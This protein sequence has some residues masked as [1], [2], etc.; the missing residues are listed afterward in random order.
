MTKKEILAE[1]IAKGIAQITILE[2]SAPEQ[3]N[4]SAVV[5][6]GQID[7][8]RKFMESRAG[9]FDPKKSHAKINKTTG[10]IGLIIDETNP[11]DFYQITGTIQQ[12]RKFQDLKIN[13][14][15]K[16]STAELSLKLRMLRSLFTSVDEH[17][18][19]V[20]DLRN[21]NAKVNKTIEK[22]DDLKGNMSDLFTQ[23]VESNI[24][25][26][27]TLAVPIIEG[28]EKVPIQVNIILTVGDS[29]QIL[30]EL[31]SVDAAEAW[32]NVIEK[33]MKEE[34]AFLEQNTTAIFV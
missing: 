7:A 11:H 20:N 19:I 1:M 23:T 30:C 5:I 9:E 3:L 24:P 26:A 29:R 12:S 8:P 6:T 32:D 4:P 18:K 34:I 21:L 13:T 17:A 15:H 31:E 14:G 28:G 16:Y 25:S 27:I 33:T 10:S 22:A 2:G